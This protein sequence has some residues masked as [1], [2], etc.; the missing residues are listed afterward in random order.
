MT[1]VAAVVL[2]AGQSSRYRAQG[3]VGETKLAAAFEG[4]PI[5]RRAVEAALASRA[6]PVVVV[7]GHARRAVESALGGLP[8]AIVFNPN[9]ANGLSTSLRTGLGALPDDVD[10]A[11][12]L[13]GDMP[14]VEAQLIDAVIDAFEAQPNARA[15]APLHGGRR[16][17]PALLARSLFPAAMRLIGDEGAR[18]L[19]TTLTSDEMVEID[20]GEW[21]AAFD[22]DTPSDLASRPPHP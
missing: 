10:G 5:V 22:I 20:A 2:A 21:D 19:L 1:R 12:I 18:K 9:Y 6:R 11:L 13:L 8:A 17:N 14:K 3:G 15:V 7:V 4:R 16:G